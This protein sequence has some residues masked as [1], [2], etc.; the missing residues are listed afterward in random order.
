M[1]TPA[2]SAIATL[3]FVF[4]ISSLTPLVRRWLERHGYNFNPRYITLP[5]NNG[6]G[7]FNPFQQLGDIH[8]NPSRVHA[9]IV[10]I[11][12]AAAHTLLLPEDVSRPDNE[13]ER[14]DA[15]EQC[16]LRQRIRVTRCFFEA[17]H[18]WLII[19]GTH[20]EQRSAA[21][22]RLLAAAIR[23]VESASFQH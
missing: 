12:T 20:V 7:A 5:G 15:N 1:A 8:R 21:W 19:R 23:I 11:V 2:T 13:C 18:S 3:W 9:S 16:H 6:S 17:R 22:Y 4:I 10:V 14:S